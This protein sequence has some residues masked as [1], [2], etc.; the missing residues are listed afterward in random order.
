[1]RNTGN[2]RNGYTTKDVIPRWRFAVTRIRTP[3]WRRHRAF[4]QA[5][6]LI[7]IV[8]SAVTAVSSTRSSD[9][10][11]VTLI[12]PVTAGTELSIEDLD[13]VRVPRRL[14]PDGTLPSVDAGVGRIIVASGNP[15]QI[16]T[17]TLLVDPESTARL[18][19]Q[20]G[21]GSDRGRP[22]LVPLR[23]AD[24]AVVPF[25]IHG[26]TV[27]VLAADDGSSVTDTDRGTPGVAPEFRVVAEEARV[28]LAGTP[29]G[30]LG[31]DAA[32]VLLALPE[33]DARAVAAVS[34]MY[35]VTVVLTGSRAVAAE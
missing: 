5:T 15:G 34:L 33:Q 20:A 11:A 9:P 35:P 27:T 26:D 1:M 19:G 3:G 32:T 2:D 29:A 6:A 18:L 30:A 28:V 14:Q 7:L 31:Q 12:R 25:L 17:T 8:L 24:P 10:W 16:L 23:L 13:L 21:Q 4:R 22:T